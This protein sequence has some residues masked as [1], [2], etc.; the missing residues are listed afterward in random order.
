MCE[1]ALINDDIKSTTREI[2]HIL[3][4]I[5]DGN[6][7]LFHELTPRR[8]YHLIL[9]WISTA[10]CITVQHVTPVAVVG[11]LLVLLLAV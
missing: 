3:F 5:A 4:L 7:W 2:C 9:L 10:Q 1:F 6:T 8:S 11:S